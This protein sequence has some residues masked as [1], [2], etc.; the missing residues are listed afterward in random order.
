MKGTKDENIKGRFTKYVETAIKRARRDYIKE[1][2]KR[3]SLEELTEP[4][5]LILQH[6]NNVEEPDACIM[7]QIENIPWEPEAIEMFLKEKT[8]IAMQKALYEL[9]DRELLIV[10][11]KVFRQMTFTEI[12]SVMGLE[13]K[14]VASAYSYARKKMKKGW[15]K[16]EL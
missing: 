10:F 11:A 1:V 2:Q 14:R 3:N 13:G 9:T 6:A 15:E 16:N 8:D 4:E 5:L 7:E 12:G